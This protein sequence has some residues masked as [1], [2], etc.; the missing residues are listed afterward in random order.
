M[1]LSGCF[2]TMVTRFLITCYL[3]SI[4]SLNLVVSPLPTC[5]CGK[6]S[7]VWANG[8][9]VQLTSIHLPSRCYY[10]HF[11]IFALILNIASLI[12]GRGTGYF[13]DGTWQGRAPQSLL[14]FRGLGWKPCWGREML[15]MLGNRGGPRSPQQPRASLV[16]SEA[17]RL[18]AQGALTPQRPRGL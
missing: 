4:M 15:S 5:N 13:M 6:V 10:Y 14:M 8:K 3:Y 7:K 9:T 1:L 11:S 16:F 18:V 17:L 2:N 12:C